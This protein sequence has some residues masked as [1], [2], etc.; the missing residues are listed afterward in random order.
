MRHRLSPSF[1]VAVLALVLAAGGVGYAAGKIGSPQIKDNSAQSRDLKNNNLQGVDVKN[2]T[3]TNSDVQKGSL[4]REVLD[5]RCKGTEIRAFGGCVRKASTGPSSYQAAIDN[6]TTRG[7]RMLTTSE[8]Q[9]VAAHTAYGWADGNPANYE[10]SSDYT[11]AVP[12]GPLAFDRNFNS[13]GAAVA[14]QLLW[15]HCLT[16]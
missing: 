4:K 15:H 9:W 2:R 7:G 1:V 3:L 10:F 14:M 8:M 16:Y 13:Y 11:S 5:R 12:I 6:C